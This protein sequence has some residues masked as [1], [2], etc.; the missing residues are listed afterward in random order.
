LVSIGA[1]MDD[2]SRID[3]RWSMRQ[4]RPSSWLIA[5]IQDEVIGMATVIGGIVSVGTTAGVTGNLARQLRHEARLTTAGPS[6]NAPSLTVGRQVGVE[7]G[8]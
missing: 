5:T 7:S 1:C 4:L 3:V 2:A 8:L 6:S